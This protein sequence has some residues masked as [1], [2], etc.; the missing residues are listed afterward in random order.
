MSVLYDA[1]SAEETHKPT[2][3]VK[4]TEESDPHMEP[5]FTI[6]RDLFDSTFS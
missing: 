5:V 2:L 6:Q 3:H 1:E 4:V